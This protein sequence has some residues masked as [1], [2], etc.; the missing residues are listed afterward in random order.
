MYIIKTFFI[1]AL[2]QFHDSFISKVAISHITGIPIFTCLIFTEILKKQKSPQ[3]H[4]IYNI[5]INAVQ[6]FVQVFYL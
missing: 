2:M 3:L 4:R 5:S 6:L 1:D